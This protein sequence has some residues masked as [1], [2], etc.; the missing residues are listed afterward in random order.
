MIE[1]LEEANVERG[2]EQEL[3]YRN[4]TAV[5]LDTAREII[6]NAV[7]RLPEQIVREYARESRIVP[8]PWYAIKCRYYS[9]KNC[10]PA[11]LNLLTD[12]VELARAVL[13][14]QNVWVNQAAL[15]PVES[16][17]LQLAK[18]RRVND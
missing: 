7:G 5:A 9:S 18:Q 2:T 13:H 1:S 14:L 17:N 16:L 6:K 15:P 4:L 10:D 8:E 3:R 12:L 11:V